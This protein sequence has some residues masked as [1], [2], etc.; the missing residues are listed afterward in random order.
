MPDSTEIYLL[1]TDVLTHIASREDASQ[2]YDGLI[3]MASERRVRSVRQVFDELKRFPSA[4]D[5][6]RAH[7][8]IFQIPT[9]EQHYPR[10]GE[11]IDLLGNEMPNLWEQTGYKNPDPADPWLVAVAATYDYTVVTD[12][13]RTSPSK[14]PAAC[15]L[16]NVNCRCI[17]GP[18]FLIKVGLV[19]DIRPEDIS[20]AS[21][22][23][24][25]E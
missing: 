17:S 16:S 5:V 21:F 14:I 22:F 1:D 19:T 8:E 3:A 9:R 24:R 23:R 4:F 20:P 7:R 10:V 13:S 11:F 25:H 2:I 18:H 6:L 15:R 12:E